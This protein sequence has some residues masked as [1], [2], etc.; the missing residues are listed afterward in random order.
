MSFA[1]RARS[2]RR[3]LTILFGAATLALA[4]GTSVTA[5]DMITG[6]HIQNGSLTGLDLRNRT[7]TGAD[8]RDGS[9]T[10]ADY[11]GV[12]QGPRGPLGPPGAAGPLGPPGIRDLSYPVSPPVRTTPGSASHGTAVCPVG[13]APIAG[14]FATDGDPA[15]MVVTESE[16][17]GLAKNLGWRTYVTNEGPTALVGYAWAVCAL[18]G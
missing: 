9:L 3:V 16:P 1:P 6:R 8:I 10:P 2:W 15:G 17:A 12:V 14:G 7:T 18:P 13:S 11:A 5:A 4:L